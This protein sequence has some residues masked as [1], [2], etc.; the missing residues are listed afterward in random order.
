MPSDNEMH[1]RDADMQ[2]D[3]V[4]LQLCTKVAQQDVAALGRLLQ[5]W[6]PW[7][8]GRVRRSL[9]I[10]QPA[11]RRP[12]DV[13]QEASVLALRFLSDFRGE[14]RQELR[15]WLSAIL[16][17]AIMQTHRYSRAEKRADL[18]T[19][20]IDEQLANPSL[21]LSQLVS[22]RQGYREV[23]AEITRLPVRQ[24]EVL[25]LRLLEERSL[26]E[27]AMQLHESEQ[28]IASLLKRGLATLRMR[29]DPQKPRI[30]RRTEEELDIALQDYLRRVDLGQAPSV[31]AFLQEYP[32][33]E[34]ELAPLLGWLQ[35]IRDRLADSERS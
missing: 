9:G 10:R 30:K 12:S 7:L 22:N 2:P 28:A 34:H 20:E 18:Q 14:S 5:R 21:R 15:A 13:V 25:Y 6:R 8:L 24:R 19:T 23:V 32:A 26:E 33:I 3:D 27:M 4:E 31:P 29:I 35:D 1:R 16:Q 11:G 17:T